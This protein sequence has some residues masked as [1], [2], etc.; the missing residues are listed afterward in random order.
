VVLAVKTSI[1]KPA[2]GSKHHRKPAIMAF[3]V[4]L[5]TFSLISFTAKADYA[6]VSSNTVNLSAPL[7]TDI[8]YA[9]D[10]LPYSLVTITGTNVTYIAGSTSSYGAGGSDVWLTK[11]SQRLNVF[12]GLG[13]YYQ[14]SVTWRK[15]FGGLQ[16]DLAKSI[17][18]SG[19]GNLILAGQ[20]KSYG[21]GGSDIYI[22]KIDLD[23]N[24]IWS[25]T[26]GG[27]LDD[28][29]NAVAQAADGGYVIAGYTTD[30]VG[31]SNAYL[32]KTD[33]QGQLL[34]NRT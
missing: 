14:D 24:Q 8:S 1:I 26:I 29:A 20:T 25:R 19:D 15:T 30:N 11:I 10:E 2:N 34:W 32:I 13:S 28:G 22:L 3:L 12:P 4:I 9:K 17:I 5:L 16:D 33:S 21:A 31:V 6:P 18:Q 27:V 23:G 7:D